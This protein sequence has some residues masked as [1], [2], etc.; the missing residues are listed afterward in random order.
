MV[1]HQTY[2]ALLLLHALAQH[3]L[4]Q[5]RAEMGMPGWVKEGRRFRV[6]KQAAA[7]PLH[8]SI[9]CSCTPCTSPPSFCFLPACSMDLHAVLLESAPR[10][11]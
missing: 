3:A 1:P 4:Q 11:L 10:T 7:L 2:I 9:L 6:R 5:A 8:A